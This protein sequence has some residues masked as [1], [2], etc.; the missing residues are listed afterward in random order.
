MATRKSITESFF[1]KIEMIP[2]SGC[3]MWIAALNNPDGYGVFCLHK[4]RRTVLAHRF[5]WEFHNGPITD[6]LFVLHKCDVRSCVNPMHLFLGT[7]ADNV[8]DAAR[9]GRLAKHERHH[10]AVLTEEQVKTIR[11]RYV[12]GEKQRALVREYG[13][14]RKVIGSICRNE[15][16]RGI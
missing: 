16:W 9:K 5:S 4:P 8:R 10:Q 13:V 14:S 6:G 12:A 1:S 11:A 7:Q 2:W 15:S 3:W